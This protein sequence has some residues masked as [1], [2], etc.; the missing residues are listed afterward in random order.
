LRLG[1]V[2]NLQQ[3]SNESQ[4]AFWKPRSCDSDT[5]LSPLS[6]SASN[7][8]R[9]STQAPPNRK[10]IG[11]SDPIGFSFLN[12]RN[13]GEVLSCGLDFSMRKTKLSV[14]TSD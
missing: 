8:V 10:Q 1:L 3:F 4:K 13:D 12:L 9:I 5:L 11:G 2:A 6:G 14:T 7:A